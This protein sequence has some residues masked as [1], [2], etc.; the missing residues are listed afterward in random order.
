[1]PVGRNKLSK[2]VSDMCHE[3][4]IDGHKNNHSL[5]ATGATQLYHA[6]VPEKIIQQRTGH[7]SLE[8]L[9]VYERTSVQ[10]NRAVMNIL[11]PTTRPE[12]C[13]EEE[14]RRMNTS[15]SQNLSPATLFN[16]SLQPIM[17][18]SG[19]TVNFNLRSPPTASSAPSKLPQE[20]LPSLD[21]VMAFIK[22]VES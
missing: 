5:R 13:F 18:F 3:A 21:D 1:M 2:V 19:Y 11:L 14:V 4:Q 9:R 6:G 12:V 10:Q 7:H 20:I 17:N 8:S 22:D 15:M 16:S